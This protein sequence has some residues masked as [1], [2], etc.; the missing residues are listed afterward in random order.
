V[1]GFLGLNPQQF[2]ALVF[3]FLRITAMLFVFP[4]FSS[5]Q[6]PM[7]VRFGLSALLAYVVYHSVTLPHLEVTP[8]ELVVGSM[9]QVLIGVIVGFTSSLVF[10]GISF[11]GELIDI[12]VGFAIANVINPV[13]QQNITII[14]EL[15]LALATLLFI[16]TDSHFF[17]I[18]G[19]AG[20]FNLVPIP[21]ITLDPSVGGNLALFFAQSFLIVFQ[22]AAPVVV[23]L[24]LTNVALAF[25]ARVAP[26]MNVFVVGLPIQV[27][28]GLTMM[29]VALPLM[30]NVGPQLFSN[31]AQE[32]DTI[33]RG[34][35]P[36]P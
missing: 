12:Q 22:I 23:A 31:M 13:T 6:M 24:F 30:A 29:I 8:F 1:H 10:N 34:L 18:Q 9:A 25:M 36:S 21:Y 16:A 17:L 14:G 4:V 33:M 28:V 2:E 15:Q 32:M 26:Q 35:R 27:T 7:Q 3:I 19:V 20:S 5:P 11:A